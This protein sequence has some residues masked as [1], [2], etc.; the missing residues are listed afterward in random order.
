VT[1]RIGENIA[2]EI[3]KLFLDT[4]AELH[5]YACTLPNV[6]ESKADDLVQE[7]FNAAALTW[8]KLAGRDR[9]GRRAWLFAVVRNKTIDQWRK[10]RSSVPSPKLLE[11]PS[12]ADVTADQVLSE[13]ALA[14]CWAVIQA[15][16]PVRK[17]VAFLRWRE[18]W[19]SAEIAGWLG[20]SQD[21]VRGHLRVARGELLVQAGA[22]VP[23]ISDP[24]IDEGG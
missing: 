4:A 15:M 7:A 20:I 19:T 23:F 21:T 2:A 14:K 9:S 13:M 3:A 18:D 12:W 24:E 5:A 22:D 8:D 1:R 6:D 10:D 11:A 17:K 16:P